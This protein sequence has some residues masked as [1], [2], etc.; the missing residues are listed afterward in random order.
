[1]S[2]VVVVA[3]IR[4]ADGQR[5]AVEQVVRDVLIPGTHREA[6]CITFAL[7]RD[8]RDPDRLV[9]IERWADGAALAAHLETAH[10][11]DFRAQVGA[12][13]AGPADVYVLEGVAAGDAVKG[14]LGAS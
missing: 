5:D 7:H 13:S 2:E 9:I 12:L 3:V 4:S 8:T 1:M 6:G 11:A 10:L 14:M